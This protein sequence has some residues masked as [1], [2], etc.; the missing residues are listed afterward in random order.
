L[1][2]HYFEDVY[3]IENYYYDQIEE[4]KDQI[5]EQVWN[6]AVSMIE[7][8]LPEKC[9]D[10]KTV[11]DWILIFADIGRYGCSCDSCGKSYYQQSF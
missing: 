4:N 8:R 10:C 2:L 1:N 3:F 11:L 6:D 5:L 7:T 9:T